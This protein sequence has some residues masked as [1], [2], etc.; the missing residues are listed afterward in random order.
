MLAGFTEEEE[1][2][3]RSKKPSLE[4]VQKLIGLYSDIFSLSVFDSLVAVKVQIKKWNEETKES[5][6]SMKLASGED[7]N[8]K[9]FEYSVLYFKNILDFNKVEQDLIRQVTPEQARTAE[10]MA[11]DIND[12]ERI[13][14]MING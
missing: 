10:K 11:N 9:E 12:A 3:L 4:L 5:P 14:R 7:V 2:N 13:Q 6:S 8:N 1:I